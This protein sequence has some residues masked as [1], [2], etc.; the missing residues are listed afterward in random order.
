MEDAVKE[1]E[2]AIPDSAV[3]QDVLRV[4]AF[5]QHSRCA[6]G[7]QKRW[8]EAQWTAC[9]RS[10]LARIDE[11]DYEQCLQRV[12]HTLDAIIRSS[13]VVENTNGRLRRFFDS[14]RGHITQARLNL[15]RFYLNHKPFERGQRQGQ[16]PAQLFHGEQASPEHWLTL[17]QHMKDAEC[18]PV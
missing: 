11:A 16:S 2:T 4:Y 3:R 13:S 8:L 6:S 14:A 5:Q 17:L 1:L 15:L 7:K 18:P 10:L 9:C 12:T